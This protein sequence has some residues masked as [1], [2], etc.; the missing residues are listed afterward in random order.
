MRRGLVAVAVAVAMR[1]RHDCRGR[2]RGLAGKARADRVAVCAGR[3]VGHAGPSAGRATDR[4]VRPE[5]LRREQGRRRRPDRI[6]RGGKRG[7]GW[8]HVPDFEHRH[9]RDLAGDQPQSCLRPAAPFH[10]YCLSRGAAQRHRRAPL[11]RGEDIQGTAGRGEDRHRRRE[12]HFA[13]S[14]NH[15]ASGAGAFGAQG[16]P[17]IRP[18]HLQGRGAGD[19]R[20]CRRPRQDGFGDLEF[21][22]RPDSRR[23]GACRSRCRRRARCRNF[24]TCRP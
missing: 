6:G 7:A 24:R 11:A 5:L 17:E 1:S 14:G 19:D 9:A 3:H 20:S 21:G 8:R 16:K 15:R 22:A 2:R 13:R 10:S 12:L 4:Q 23:H 18:R